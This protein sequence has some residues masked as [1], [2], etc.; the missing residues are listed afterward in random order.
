MT[1]TGIDGKEPNLSKIELSAVLFMVQKKV[2]MCMNRV[3][4]YTLDYGSASDFAKMFREK[5]REANTEASEVFLARA[6]AAEKIS[7]DVY[8]FDGRKFLFV[9]N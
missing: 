6:A 5:A 7:G 9:K 3:R 8:L 1:I 2:G 4:V